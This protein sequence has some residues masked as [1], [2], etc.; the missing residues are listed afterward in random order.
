[1]VQRRARGGIAE[2]P[3][4]VRRPACGRHHH[5]RQRRPR[6]AA[7]AGRPLTAAPIIK[8]PFPEVRIMV[9]NIPAAIGT[10]IEDIDTPCLLI[11]LDAYERNVERMARFMQEHG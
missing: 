9:R 10:R 11:D 2:A 5:R 8:A 4:T 3:R 7:L 6:P 1:T